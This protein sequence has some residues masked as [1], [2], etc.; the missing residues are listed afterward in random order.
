MLVPYADLHHTLRDVLVPLGMSVERADVC[1]TLFADASRDGVSS[2]G[3]NRFPRFV[4]TIRNGS[5]D[6]HAEP[7]LVAAHAAL[8]RWDGRA[9]PGP[10]NAFASMQRAITLGKTHGIGCVALSNTN[11]WMRGGAYGWQAADAGMI[12]MCWTNT[13]AN[14]PAWGATEPRLGNNP[15][16]IALPRA[17]EHVVLDMAMSQFSYG[18]LAAYR[19][20]GEQLPVDGG[21]DADGRLTR[22][23]AAIEATGRMLPVGF[24]KGSG[25]A[26]VLDMIA[27]LL[28]GGHATHEIP[29]DG[30]RETGLSQVFIAVDPAA[31]GL[32]DANVVDRILADLRRDVGVR[33]PGERVVEVRRRSLSE[34]VMVDDDIWAEVLSVIPHEQER[35]S[36]SIVPPPS[37]VTGQ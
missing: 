22:D 2:H 33:Y 13:L 17:P 10:L 32:D 20:R 25:L 11:H 30:D 3:L 14:L 26:L 34:G 18:S 35:V 29:R 28:S 16:V 37:P 23:P 27:A 31:L 4:R 24:W 7:I 8:E 9:G 12:G 19:A 15:L 6:V 21:Y 5:V 36:G 1:A